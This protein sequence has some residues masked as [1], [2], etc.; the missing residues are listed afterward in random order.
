MKFKLLKSIRYGILFPIDLVR[1]IPF[2]LFCLFFPSRDPKR[3]AKR[4]LILFLF[5]KPTDLRL[6]QLSEILTVSGCC[7]WKSVFSFFM[8]PERLETKVFKGWNNLL[9]HHDARCLLVRDHLPAARCI[10]DLGGSGGGVPGGGLLFMGYP[11]RPEKVF[12]VDLPPQSQF[13]KHQAPLPGAH[14]YAG[15]HVYYV[16]DGMDNLGARGSSI[17]MVC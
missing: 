2:L 14:P 8:L 5:R 11:H 9:S 10:V 12:V 6:G 7:N 4:L 3:L 17:E 1:S 13:W 15:T 16:Y